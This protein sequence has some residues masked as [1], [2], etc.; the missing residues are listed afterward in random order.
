MTRFLSLAM[1]C[2]SLALPLQAQVEGSF[3][4]RRYGIEQG[5]GSEVVSALVQDPAG[6]LW[7]GTEGGLCFFDGRRFYP[8]TGKLPSQFIT[9]LFVDLD[10]ALWVAT[11]GGLAR[12][13][14]GQSR[15]FGPADG[16]P[17]GTVK[18]VLR[19]QE[20]H[21]WVLTS[22]GIRVEGAPHGFVTPTPWPGQELPTHLFADPSLSGAW[23]ITSQTIWHWR[24]GGWVRLESPQFAPGEVL[25]DVAVDGDRNVW[26]RTSSS[27]WRLPADGKGTWIGT[28]VVGGYSHISKL[29]RDS[30]GWVW[31]DTVSGLWRVKNNQREQFG[32]AQDDARGGMVDQEGGLWLRTDKGILRVL[33]QTRWHTYGPQD[34][35]PQDTTW[36]MIR[37][38][39]GQLWVGMDSGLWVVRGRRF[40]RVA[41]GRFLTLTLA[42]DGTL[43]ASGSPGGTIHLVNTRTLVARPLRIEAL[44]VDRLTAGVA[45]EGEGRPWVANQNGGVVRGSRSGQAWTWSLMP[46]NGAAPREVNGL[47][48]LPGGGILMLHEGKGSIWKDGAWQSVPDMLPEL[49]TAADIAPDGRVIISY[50]NRPVLTLH[51]L[52]GGTL[53]RD[54]VLDLAVPW[55]Q[56]TIYSVAFGAEGRIWVGTSKG[57][58][59]LDAG[60]SPA[61]HILGTEDRII[62]S[63]CDEAALLVEPGRIWVGSPSGLMSHDL[64]P[65]PP[66]QG[67][68]PPLVISA[69]AGSRELDP[70]DPYLELSKASNDLEVRFM[71][72]NYQIQDSLLYAAKLSGVDA[73]WI[74]M[75]TPNLRYTGLQAGPHVLELRGLTQ[76]GLQGPVT[77]FRF[78]VRAAW[79]ERWW[80]RALGLL[81]LA[82]LVITLVKARQAQLE[83]SNRELV[84]EV[85]RQTSELVA[86]S[87]AKSAFLANMSHE[88]RT[89]L[90]A[91]LLYSEIMQEDM[92]DPVMSGHRSDA[93]KIHSAGQHLLG[94]I[95]DILDMSKIEAGHLRLDFQQI[96]VPTFLHDLD[97]TIRPLAEKNGN[98]FELDLQQVPELICS[99]PTRLRQILVNLLSNSAKFTQEGMVLLKAQG[100]GGQLVLT[101][102]DSGIGMTAEQQARVFQEFVQADDSTTRKFGG[103]GLGL[104]LVKKFTDLLG[105]ELALQSVP[106]Q[107]TTF[108][109]KFPLAGPPRGGT[110]GEQPMEPPP[111]H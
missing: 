68:R 56:M 36:Q 58:G 71:V 40:K 2:L 34:G 30:E 38:Q 80:V 39:L 104:T 85:T 6:R 42:K 24:E 77:T 23:A 74:R 9:S 1:A 13:E 16:I 106:G 14:R 97:A 51:H 44:P 61:L 31:V 111:R 27:L 70:S 15:I 32:Y 4:V 20:G 72:P 37:D 86:A 45:F 10:A 52:Q 110:S 59:F 107:G 84:D 5:L 53:V 57:L 78:W 28:G 93:G 8:F 63:E 50:R 100:E 90:N 64:L 79:W 101:V 99:D 62:S 18:E 69:R 66:H 98:R 33:G 95:D 54:A 92:Q 7:V 46:I 91:I 108:T 49:P 19:D 109:L 89:P 35:L 87:K 12:I 25:Q 83:R 102:Q 88:L 96:T 65:Q 60:E 17:A 82:G 103:T 29:S 105:G 11:Q 73:D 3:P 76:E 21:L 94:L 75:D 43:W 41:K 26:V 47:F 55:T 67:L 48:H 22:Q 81:G